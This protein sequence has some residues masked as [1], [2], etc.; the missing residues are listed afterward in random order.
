MKKILFTI[1]LSSITTVSL[2]KELDQARFDC[3][4]KFAPSAIITCHPL[5]MHHPYLASLLI[6]TKPLPTAIK[7]LL[8][9]LTISKNLPPINLCYPRWPHKDGI[10][11]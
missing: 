7:P 2:A 4:T 9:L 11:R 10:I 5:K 8:T 3:M 6:T 1:L